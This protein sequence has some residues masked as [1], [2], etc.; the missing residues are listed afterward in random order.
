M[1]QMV[2][3]KRFFSHT[4]NQPAKQEKLLIETGKI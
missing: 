2:E 4:A 1:N 3:K